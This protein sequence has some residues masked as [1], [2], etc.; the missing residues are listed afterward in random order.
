MAKPGKFRDEAVRRRVVRAIKLGATRQ[1]AAQAGGVGR[2]TLQRWLAKGQAAPHGAYR[3]FW[4]EVN[5][6]EGHAAEAALA[7]IVKASQ[8]GQWQA[9]AWLL[10]RRH[11]Y[12]RQGDLHIEGA[13]D[14]AAEIK[15]S[16]IEADQV[17]ADAL[18]RLRHLYGDVHRLRRQCEM[19]GK[20]TAAMQ[21]MKQE[22]E[23]LAQIH[24]EEVRRADLDRSRRTPEQLFEELGA[25]LDAL[26]DV[27]RIRLLAERKP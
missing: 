9:A 21:A 24:D 18:D 1:L 26:P 6:A 7:T 15:D 5:Q 20:A 13:V 2:R 12:K 22:H 25:Q 17:P 8:A 27:L 10:E 19:A 16:H 4:E 3:R 11:G 14:V 23:L